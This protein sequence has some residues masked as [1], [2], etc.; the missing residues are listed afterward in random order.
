MSC[1]LLEGGDLELHPGQVVDAL[2]RLGP[3]ILRDELLDSSPSLDDTVEVGDAGL[4]AVGVLEALCG[5]LKTLTAVEVLTVVDGQSRFT[6]LVLLRNTVDGVD[7]STN[8]LLEILIVQWDFSC[9]VVV[10]LSLTLVGVRGNDILGR[11]DLLSINE[12]GYRPFQGE[13]LPRGD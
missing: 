7:Q 10:H 6:D 5:T 13:N 12:H 9:F 11:N 1:Q 4:L 2:G 3:A 8:G